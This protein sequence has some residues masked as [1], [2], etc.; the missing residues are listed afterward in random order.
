MN[1]SLAIGDCDLDYS[2]R[3]LAGLSRYDELTVHLYTDAGKLQRALAEKTFDVVLFDADISE[4]RLAFGASKLAVC[5]YREDAKNIGLY[6]DM[7]KL[8]KYQR[9]SAIYQEM[10]RLYAGKAGYSDGFDYSHRT[11]SAAVYSPVG[12]SGKTT[13]ALALA[14]QLSGQGKKVLFLSVEPLNSSLCVNPKKGEGLVGLLEASASETVNFELKLK[15][16]VN[17]GLNGMEYAEGF[18]RLADYDAVA[19]GEL[20]EVLSKIR[21]SGIY[22]A[23]VL[24]LG[25]RLDWAGRE[26]LD[27]ADRILIVEREGDLAKEKLELF[28]SQALFQEYKGKCAGVLNFAEG[29]SR[30]KLILEIPMTGSIP[31]Y[32]SIP[33]EDLI[34]AIARNG[35][36]GAERIGTKQ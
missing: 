25:S 13:V 7:E 35:E 28:S 12:G 30:Q 1:I 8:S 10:A 18:E 36:L 2:E 22:D 6:P 27:F 20:A 16:T 32:G 26:A 33:I 34:S 24:D 9:I 3:L 5:L 19:K 4:E 31:Y 17:S 14:S 11:D 29:S 21:R 15:G 23:I